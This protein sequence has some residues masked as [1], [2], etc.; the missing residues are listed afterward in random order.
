VQFAFGPLLTIIPA[1]AFSFVPTP[2]VFDTAIATT[3]TR[4]YGETVRIGVNYHFT[5][6]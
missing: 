1:G 4:F 6:N 2:N 3:S 5:R